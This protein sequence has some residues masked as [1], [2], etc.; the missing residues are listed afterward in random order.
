MLNDVKK[1]ILAISSCL[2]VFIAASTI[3]L[4]FIDCLG[5]FLLANSN[6]LFGLVE[7]KGSIAVHLDIY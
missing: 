5:C 7:V 6:E 2:F 1:M 3:K 4:V